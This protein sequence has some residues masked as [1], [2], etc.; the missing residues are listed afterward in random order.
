MPNLSFNDAGLAVV[1]YLKVKG[2]DGTSS[3]CNSG[4]A[5]SK[6]ETGIYQL[7]L[8]DDMGEDASRLL[9]F[10]QPTGQVAHLVTSPIV[11][12]VDPVDA[13][14]ILVGTYIANSFT[15]AAFD[16]D[17][18]VLLMRTVVPPPAGAPA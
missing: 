16:S 1:A 4:V 9:A 17:F 5:T 7:V 3:D 14:T 15:I 2:S 11:S 18:T 12:K 6:V 10:V 8:P 13:R